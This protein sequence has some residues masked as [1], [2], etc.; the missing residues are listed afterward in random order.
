MADIV[1][2]K[3][4]DFDLKDLLTEWHLNHLY[5]H[6]IGK[7]LNKYFLFYCLIFL[8]IYYLLNFFFPFF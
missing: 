3:I 8:F 7:I 1:N 4:D 2:N 6:F 5:E